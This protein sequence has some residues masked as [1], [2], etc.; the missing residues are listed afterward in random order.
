MGQCIL[1]TLKGEVTDTSLKKINEWI[2][3]LIER[4]NPM[5]VI[6][7]SNKV[8]MSFTVTEPITLTLENNA[9]FIDVSTGNT[10]LGNMLTTGTGDVTVAINITGKSAVHFSNKHVVTK[11]GIYIEAGGSKQFFTDFAGT[12]GNTLYMPQIYTKDLKF[13]ALS[14]LLTGQVDIVGDVADIN[15]SKLDYLL[16]QNPYFDENYPTNVYSNTYGDATAILSKG[17]R[18]INTTWLRIEGNL[19]DFKT[20]NIISG[21]FSVFTGCKI[22][23]DIASFKLPFAT[24]LILNSTTYSMYRLSFKD[25]GYNPT[26]DACTHAYLSNNNIR[27]IW[28]KNVSTLDSNLGNA[29][30]SLYFISNANGGSKFTYTKNITRQYIIATELVHMDT[31]DMNNFLIEMAKL[32]ANPNRP[33]DGFYKVI[34]LV[35]TRSAISDAAVATL[36][37][38]G[39]TVTVIPEYLP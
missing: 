1:H 6:G 5:G 23:G 34:S 14:S 19:S 18:Y 13:V 31:D 7:R 28:A 25:I 32:S 9:T 16:I 20:D 15:A 30:D 38:K 29:P 8:K 35:G 24:S 12:V 22:S 39:Y 33:T 36:S 17:M 3:P 2:F 21:L 4:P 26:G 11:L 27:E 37:G 10:D